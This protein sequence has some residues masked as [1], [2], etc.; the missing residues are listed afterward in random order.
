MHYARFWLLL[1]S[2]GRLQAQ[3]LPC[4]PL[5]HNLVLNPGFELGYFG[6]ASDFGRGLNNATRCDCNTQGWILVASI[7]PHAGF[8]CQGYPADWSVQYGAPNTFTHPDPAHPSNT[9][10]ATTALCNAPVPDHTSGS[11]LFLTVDPDACPDRAYW[12]QPLQVCANTTYF[13]SVWVRNLAGMPAP[14]FHF[15][16][17]GT[18]VTTSTSYPE[19]NWVQTSVQWN[20][21]GVEGNVWLELVNDLPGCDAND[22]AVDDLFFGVCAGISL[23]SES[24]FRFCPGD[25]NLTLQLS[26]SAVGFSNPQYQW[27][28]RV[29]GAWINVPGATD[30]LLIFNAPETSDAGFYRLAA[31]ENGN[32][33][34]PDCS[35]FGPP[36]ELAPYPAYH[37]TDTVSICEGEQYLGLTASG[38]YS[39]SYLT[40]QGCDSVRT[41]DLRVKS[42]LKWFVPNVFSPD[43]DGDNDEIT[44]FLSNNEPDRYCWQIF[45][46]WGNMVF[47]SRRPG[48]SWSGDFRGKPCAP[49]VYFF[50]LQM[51]IEG[52]QQSIWQGEL[53]LLR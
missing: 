51:E 18:E 4:N 50:V 15:E 5:G 37:I 47:E 44:P 33:A 6:F 22:V 39:R 12:R 28:K 14:T 30:T 34:A 17:G 21:G 42:E 1:F 35:V 23:S 38:L 20:S 25:P 9:S 29:G 3:I 49:G 52:C 19:N 45:D 41:L 16:V 24:L 46:R 8:S 13:F 32:I 26:G 36:I 2:L 10:V 7:N 11:G 31:A 48:Q 43:G 53:T 40:L 27:Q